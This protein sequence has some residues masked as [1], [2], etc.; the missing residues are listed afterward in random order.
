MTKLWR[1][2]CWNFEIWAVQRNVNLIDL[3]KWSKILKN[4]P[5]LAIVAVDT[6]ENGPPKVWGELFSLFS[7]L[8]SDYACVRCVSCV[9]WDGVREGE[10]GV[11][12]SNWIALVQED[13]CTSRTSSRCARSPGHWGSGKLSWSTTPPLL[14]AP[15]FFSLIPSSDD[16][17][18]S[19]VASANFAMNNWC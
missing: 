15:S 18:N 11:D 9:S 3:E 14:S 16:V 13:A 17:M 12:L 19:Q 8:L 4:A 1:L 5:T 7:R 10:R 2:F 6:A